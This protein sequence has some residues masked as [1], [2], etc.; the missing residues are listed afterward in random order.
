MADYPGLQDMARARDA[1]GGAIVET[2][3]CRWDSPE[4]TDAVPSGTDVILK[5]EL[6]QKTGTFKPRGAIVN[7]LRLDDAQRQRGITAVSAGNHAIAAAYAAQTVGASAKVVMLKSA[8]AIRREKCESYG[9]EV[10][11]AKDVHAAFE[12]AEQIERE[13]G[14][15]FIHPFEGEG[16]ALGTG[17]LG[18]EFQRQASLDAVIIPIGGGGLC[19]GVAAAL[20]QLNPDIAVYGVEPEGA[21]S[22][23]LSFARGEPARID[24]VRSIADSLG[25]PFA[26]PYSYGVCRRFVD[27]IVLVDDDAL[28][29]A[30]RRL[31]TGMKLAVEPAGAAATAALIGPLRDRL[32][33]QRVG[34]IVC[35]SNIGIADYAGIVGR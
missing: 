23:S 25:A 33:G 6:F 1:I 32:A 29:D 20:K 16:V 27:D 34:L 30:M 13:E 4:I 5:L 11:L 7:A 15:T 28:R 24:A 8:S 31:F 26:M 22:M 35:G 3:V 18:L 10:V 2:P 12:L 21:N 14:R 19:A 17:T 9:A